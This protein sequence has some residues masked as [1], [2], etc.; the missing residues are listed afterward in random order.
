MEGKGKLMGENTIEITTAVP[1]CH[2]G[3]RHFEPEAV[4]FINSDSPYWMH[5]QCRHLNKCLAAIDQYLKAT[6]K[7]I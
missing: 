5:Y 4:K 2:T 1:G 3:C 7:E 6:A